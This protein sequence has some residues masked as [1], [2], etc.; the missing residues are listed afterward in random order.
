M[1]ISARPKAK[2]MPSTFIAV[3]PDP[4]PPITAAP[5]PKKTSVKVPMNSAIAFCMASSEILIDA[6]TPCHP[7]WAEKRNQILEEENSAKKSAVKAACLT[8]ENVLLLF[9]DFGLGGEVWRRR[10][11][12]DQRLKPRP[13]FARGAPSS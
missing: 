2:A 7:E 1:A 6:I 10:C 13:Q 9:G 3:G 8:R 12:C 4:M 11:S 5:Q